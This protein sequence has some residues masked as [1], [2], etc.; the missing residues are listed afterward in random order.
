LPNKPGH[1]LKFPEVEDPRFQNNRHMKVGRL[2]ALLKGR[3]YPPVIM[4]G[5]HFLYW[6]SRPQS[7]SA[8]ARIM[9]LKNSNKTIGN[10]TRDLATY[11]L[12]PRP[13]DLRA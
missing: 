9:P 7:R 5:T 3:L 11:S 13:A 12:V 2:S 10:R 1:A 4:P 6:L 8:A